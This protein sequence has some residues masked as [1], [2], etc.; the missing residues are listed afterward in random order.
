MNL[1]SSTQIEVKGVKY[2]ITIEINCTGNIGKKDS[3]VKLSNLKL[4]K[5]ITHVEL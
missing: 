1:E 4:L 2:D 3:V 5:G